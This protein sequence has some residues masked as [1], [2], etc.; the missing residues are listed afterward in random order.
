LLPVELAVPGAEFDVPVLGE[1]RKAR[2]I[3]ESP[4]DPEAKRARL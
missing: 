2:V 1:M 4:Y 3:E